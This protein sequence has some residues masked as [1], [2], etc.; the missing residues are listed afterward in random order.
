MDQVAIHRL[1]IVKMEENVLKLNLK[2]RKTKI[3]KSHS[4]TNQQDNTI[5]KKKVLTKQ[6]QK[7]IQTLQ[8]N[9]S[10][11]KIKKSKSASETVKNQF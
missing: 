1:V 6:L 5:H 11:K 9:Q 7:I 8:K 3:V 10:A 4:K 2:N